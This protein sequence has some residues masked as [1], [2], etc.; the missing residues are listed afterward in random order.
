[1]L[2]WRVGAYLHRRVVLRDW[3]GWYQM[4]FEWC[5]NNNKYYVIPIFGTVDGRRP[6]FYEF[7]GQN[8]LN[9]ERHKQK[10]QAKLFSKDSTGFYSDEQLLLRSCGQ[11]NIAMLNHVIQAG[12]LWLRLRRRVFSDFCS[13]MIRNWRRSSVDKLSAGKRGYDSRWSPSNYALKKFN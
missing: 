1:M 3:C 4:Q 10:S 8:V 2:S 6:Q 13:L 7:E 5:A 9:N 12:W 11:G